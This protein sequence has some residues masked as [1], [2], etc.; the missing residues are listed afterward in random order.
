MIRRL[1]SN[2]FEVPIEKAPFVIRLYVEGSN[3]G[4]CGGSLISMLTVLTAAHCVD[5]VSR[6]L[7]VGTYQTDIFSFPTELDFYGD[8]IKVEDV[9]I[10]PRYRRN[11]TDAVIHGHDVALL[12]L[13]RVPQHYGEKPMAVPLDGGGWWPRGT[14]V[15]T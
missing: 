7:Y 1:I 10:H 13:A 15:I 3:L 9:N 8:F 6:N 4:I 14:Q 2:G 11:T 12:T 5:G